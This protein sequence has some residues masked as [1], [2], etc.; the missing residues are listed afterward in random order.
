MGAIVPARLLLLWPDQDPYLQWE[1][2][3]LTFLKKG[4]TQIK[5]IDGAPRPVHDLIG[6]CAGG[7]SRVS[8]SPAVILPEQR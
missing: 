4:S 7:K 8:N 3:K 1:T 5:H 6:I 2:Q